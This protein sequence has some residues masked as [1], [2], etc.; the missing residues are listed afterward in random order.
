[1]VRQMRKAQGLSAGCGHSHSENGA[2]TGQNE[3]QGDPVGQEARASPYRRSI[4][5]G[6]KRGWVG[7]RE[8]GKA[9]FT[10]PGNAGG[11]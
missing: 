8:E 4:A 2:N 1:M 11:C 7:E 9:F 10:G 6:A 3:A 5:S